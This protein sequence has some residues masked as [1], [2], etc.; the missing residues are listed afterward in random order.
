MS[1][2]VRIFW[3]LFVFGFLAFVLMVVLAAYGVFGKMPSLK[4]LENP[5]LLQTSEVYAADGSLMGKYYL[6]NGN[7]SNVD[8]KDISKHIV[9]AL[10][11]TEDERFKDHSGIDPKGT[12]R[13]IG[14]LGRGGGGS[15]ITQQLAKALLA[16][17]QGTNKAWRVIEKIK[18]WV[19]AVKLERNFTKEEMVALYLN[20]VPFS[21]NVFGIRNASRTFFQKEP[22]K[23][24]V[25]QAAILI[26]MVNGP[27]I[28]NPRKHPDR[29][30]DRRNLVLSRMAT[31]KYITETEANKYKAVPIK[32][33][34]RKLDENTGF[35]P[36]FR[37]I[38]K[39]EVKRELKLIKKPDG[40]N[41]DIYNDGLKIYTTINPRMQQYAEEAV[42]QHMPSMQRILNGQSDI[43]TGSAWKNHEN[44]LEA[45]MKQSER[46]NNMKEEGLSEAEIKKSFYKK[47]EMK[48]F[49]WN[50][51]REKDTTMTPYDSIK[52]HRQIMQASF[53]AMD[54]MSGEVK[55]W[56]GGVNFK[57]FKFD[58]VNLETKRQ[59]GSA[60]KPFLYAQAME[61][62]GFEPDSEVE[63]RAQ[64][65]PGSGW[66]PTQRAVSGGTMTMA[67]G[68]AYSKNGVAAYLMKQVGPQQFVNFLDE[69]NIPTK[70]KPY[71]SN[72]LGSCDLSLFEM[73]WGYTMFPSGGFSVKPFFITRIEDRNGNIIKRFDFSTTR[74]EVLSQVTAYKMARMM[75]GASVFG[76]A[77]GL[78]GSLG[79]A[80]M[81]C[82]TGTTNDNT[83]AWFM[84]FTPEL[85]A[86]G[87][88]GCDNNFIHISKNNG[89]GYGGTAAAPVW[90]NF[91]SKVLNDR[92]LGYNKNEKFLKPEDLDNAVNSA[93]P[94]TNPFSGS[95]QPGAQGQDE[96]SGDI[97][98]Y[99]NENDDQ[100]ENLGAESQLPG[101][102]N[103]VTEPPVKKDTIPADKSKN[104]KAVPIG[105]ATKDEPKK[106]GFLKKLF[107]KKEN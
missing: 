57:T 101:K 92:K 45:A 44:V 60:I 19:I 105:E 76:T 5:S 28:Y 71:P 95:E 99:F 49:A 2:A 74:K 87:W 75:E 40:T 51:K 4:E 69:I 46:W 70:L 81:G 29:S 14:T 37:E 9:N 106:K 43:K 42:S 52:Y 85:L 11:A 48:V 47:T 1:K 91:F 15:T 59:V 30:K 36:Y 38:L 16:Q 62:R 12:L 97:E 67:R 39:E 18:E 33:N 22:D 61:Q 102:E 27:G 6:E 73:M 31:N 77:K 68:L 24:T 23:V 34:Y 58:H 8:Y 80:E 50:V 65:F 94:T 86:G 54:P 84:G 78:K 82:K 10:I 3:R 7:R 83:D 103:R 64:F 20:A 98:N 63:D 41:Y 88:V 13:A 96:G 89:M 25:D 21:D 72:A 104:D 79:I 100:G 56:V 90:R 26:G 66:V 53:M 55:A 93:D 32:L 17:G 107:G 35:A